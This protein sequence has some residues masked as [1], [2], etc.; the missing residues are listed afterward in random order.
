MPESSK[1]MAWVTPVLEEIPIVDTA[2]KGVA[3]VE[4]SNKHPTVAAS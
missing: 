4:N 1:K 2:G 3:A